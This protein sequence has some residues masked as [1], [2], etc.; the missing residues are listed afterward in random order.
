MGAYSL[1]IRRKV[2][3]AYQDG[4]ISIRE[5]AKRFTMSTTTVQKLLRQYRETQDLTPKKTGTKKVSK[6]TEHREFIVK[7]VMTYPD[8]TL[9]QY[10]ESLRQHQGVDASLSIMSRFLRREGLTLKKR[11]TGVRVF[12]QKHAN[13]NGSMTNRG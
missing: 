13:R 3:A 12:S 11:P 1:D 5:V 8:W 2:V 7:M 9:T 6:L 10:C 4:K